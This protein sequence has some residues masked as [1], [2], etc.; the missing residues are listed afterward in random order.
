MAGEAG[1]AICKLS[2][3]AGSEI[4]A[5]MNPR[6]LGLV[7]LGGWLALGAEARAERL[8]NLS[9]R[10]TTDAAANV[11]TAG[12]VITGNAPK[13]VLVRAAGPA[14]TPLGVGGALDGVRLELYRGATLLQANAGW[15]AGVGGAEVRA[16]AQRV[17][18]FA[19][20]AG[21]RDAALLVELAP[22]GYTAQAKPGAVAATGVAL[23][24]VYEAEPGG[25]G[26]IGNLSARAQAG[27]GAETFI[28]GFVVA[29]EGRNRM[30]VRG[31]GPA[32][33]AFGVTDA[34]RD[35][36]LE[37]FRDGVSLGY[38]DD[39]A[40]SANAAQAAAVMQ[41]A[42]AFALADDARDAA[43][44]VPAVRGAATAHVTPAAGAAAGTVLVEVYDTAGQGA[45]PPA[46]EF[47]LV[48]F[49]RV[50][51]HGRAGLT[52]GGSPTIP[53][54]PVARTGNFW[55][56]DE[57]TIAAA[58]NAF[59]AQ[60]QAALSG[61]APLVVELETMLDLSR[62]GRPNNGA[63]A[64][65]HPEFFTPG[66]S[67]GTVGILALGSNKTIYSAY[68]TGGFRRGS[69][70][71]SGRSNVILRNLRFRELWE[72]DDA[73]R[74]EY[75]RNDWDYLVVTS[76]TSGGAV[77]ARAHH[78][79]LDHCDFERSYDGLFDFVRGADLLTVSWCKIGG[80]VSGESVRWVRRQVE[81]LE[82][83][84]A[85]FPHY[86]AQRATLTVEEIVR[87][88][89]LQKK[90]NL[91][92]NGA[93]A[94]TAA[95]D[96]GFLNVTFHHNWYVAVDQRMPR[97]RFGNAHIFNLLADSRGGRGV[98]GLSLMGVAATSNAA[99]RL[100]GSRFVGVRTPLTLTA[101]TEPLGRIAVR[102][103]TNRDGVTGADVG[104]D[105]TRVTAPEAFRWNPPA[106]A[107][108]LVGWPQAD[109][110]I[111]PAGYVPAGRALT[112]YIE[113]EAAL[114][115]RLANVGVIV[116][117]DEAQAEELR[118]RLRAW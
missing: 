41:G 97:M 116:P 56:I 113:G 30:L 13:R 74:G 100:E 45:L 26:R 47:E 71:I 37:V 17:G 65:A 58:G 48:G 52:G 14:L 105:A 8:S 4:G 89:L 46:R 79:W 104:F 90:A 62:F 87:R 1:A 10:G 53:Y 33:G 23:I 11:L 59:A 9:A 68:G 102:T 54:D 50:A 118:R 29:G 2:L 35:P 76:A 55:R 39:W 83:N 72:W 70:S 7:I 27:S 77:T 80:A 93:D 22:G 44:L 15:D 57:A 43:L 63:T 111:M 98:A 25:G 101:G 12:F 115:E 75:D 40:A 24:E 20:A 67:N 88:E 34:L 28:V 51:G 91:I 82:A 21:S 108:G 66:R 73:T 92:G 84:R 94:A 16:V 60:L 31:I 81:H 32:L 64:I 99:V 61:D 96:T 38:N 42:G 86:A 114:A 85:A 112:D 110:A 3:G 6:K 103:S 5:G 49:A 19:F 109:S 18:A 95:L 107:T 106:A 78:V 117:A 69:L 36:Q